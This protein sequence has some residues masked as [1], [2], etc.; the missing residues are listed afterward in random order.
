MA[1]HNKGG[2]MNLPEAGDIWAEDDGSYYLFL[3][4][5]SWTETH[6]SVTYMLLNNGTV[7]FGEF[8]IDPNTSTLYD[9]YQKVA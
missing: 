4:K 2:I 1:N 6:I 8:P 9:W 3:T 5:P 7:G